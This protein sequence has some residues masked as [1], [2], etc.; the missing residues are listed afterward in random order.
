MGPE[1][2]KTSSFVYFVFYISVICIG[3]CSVWCG[4]DG[5]LVAGRVF[6]RT[7][8]LS[9]QSAWPMVAPL[10]ISTVCQPYF[11]ASVICISL[12]FHQYI[13]L[14]WSND[15]NQ[16]RNCRRSSDLQTK[17]FYLLKPTWEEKIICKYLARMRKLL[18]FQ[19]P[20]FFCEDQ[21]ERRGGEVPPLWTDSA[22]FHHQQGRIDFNTGNPSLSTGKD[23][24]IHSL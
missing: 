3:E 2:L 9:I 15:D 21:A 17:P 10:L 16:L 24:L 5:R 8:P 12:K 18:P 23:F 7:C 20:F 6:N 13:S 22:F 14:H 4:L 11:S 19:P 1:G